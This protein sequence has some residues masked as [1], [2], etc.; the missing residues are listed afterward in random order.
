[1][2]ASSRLD[3]DLDD[4]DNDGDCG[5]E[6][7]RKSKFDML[8]ADIAAGPQDAVVASILQSAYLQQAIRNASLAPAFRSVTD[9]AFAL[10]LER[11]MEKNFAY[12]EK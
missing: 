8:P 5:R 11:A 4:D 1:M 12:L 3:A 10:K 2:P 6:R 9:A 7:K